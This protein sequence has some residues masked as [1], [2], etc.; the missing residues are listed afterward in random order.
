VEDVAQDIE[1]Y[2]WELATD[3]A[4]FIKRWDPERGRLDKFVVFNALKEA[5][6]NVHRQRAAY[7]LSAKS[8]TRT[9]RCEA[10][11]AEYVVEDGVAFVANESAQN[12]QHRSAG[13]SNAVE[14]L[15]GVEQPDTL[16]H[17]DLMRA[18][19]EA[20]KPIGLQVAEAI[21]REGSVDGAARYLYAQSRI[22]DA[23]GWSKQADA[24]QHVRTALAA[25]A[26]PTE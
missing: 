22:K 8:P 16:E 23:R 3:R 1:L 26:A 15:A 25:L 10:S 6:R 19:V 21:M 4:T 11:L 24:A 7:K 9:E 13:W 17:R 20:A 14:N 2:A 12:H 5:E 18:L